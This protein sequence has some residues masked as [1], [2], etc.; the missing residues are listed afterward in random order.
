MCNNIVL[1]CQKVLNPFLNH[2]WINQRM[3]RMTTTS[4]Y[5]FYLSVLFLL[6]IS[7][8][9][10][11]AAIKDVS[12]NKIHVY[13]NGICPLFIVCGTIKALHAAEIKVT[14]VAA[15]AV[16]TIV[17]P[18]FLLL[19]LQSYIVASSLLLL[20]LLLLTDKKRTQPL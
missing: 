7:G 13:R 20:L 5:S 12:V 11:I 3:T 18:V 8:C 15:A 1:L 6:I 19:P 14:A 17:D 16:A 4:T 2:E 9:S 10:S